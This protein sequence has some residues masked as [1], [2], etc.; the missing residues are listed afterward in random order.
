MSDGKC[1]LVEKLLLRR[2]EAEDLDYKESL[3]LL[4][5][6]EKKELA[7]DIA[8]FANSS[9]GYIL[10][11]VEDK[12]W[13]AVGI[14]HGSVDIN[15]ITGIANSG[16]HPPVGITTEEVACSGKTFVLL[17]IKRTGTVHEL[18]DRK[19]P[20]RH[21]D[22]TVYASSDE[23]FQMKLREAS[24]K[25]EAMRSLFVKPPLDIEQG[26]FPSGNL[27]KQQVEQV[28][29][30]LTH[31]KKSF[32]RESVLARFFRRFRERSF[33]LDRIS[34]LYIKSFL[35]SC[36]VTLDSETLEIGR[37]MLDL[38]SLRAYGLLAIAAIAAT[39]EEGEST[40]PVRI[41]L[42]VDPS[43][44]G[45][46]WPKEKKHDLETFFGWAGKFADF[47][48]QPHDRDLLSR[49]EPGV[50]KD[51]LPWLL[52]RF[53]WASIGFQRRNEI[54]TLWTEM[55]KRQIA[56]IKRGRLATWQPLWQLSLKSW[57]KLRDAMKAV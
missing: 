42:E 41:V 22:T 19:V 3:P 31:F 24:D 53:Q 8:A 10:V 13:E 1:E 12:T 43:K 4:H 7:K 25:V 50:P 37:D 52:E 48:E 56:V 34:D 51:A 27:S 47:Q 15:K 32:V 29:N 40:R 9:G 49:F 18:D 33:F 39:S 5:D 23:I 35:E 11:G 55:L 26:Q 2:A 17:H 30:V 57:K 6:R 36:S 38:L 44:I 28:E 21:G 14:A 46:G 54:L 16:I 20:I 45:L